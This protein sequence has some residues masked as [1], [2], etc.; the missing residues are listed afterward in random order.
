MLMRSGTRIGPADVLFNADLRGFI[1]IAFPQL[2]PDALQ[3]M[4]RGA[5]RA[6]LLFL[7]QIVLDGNARK[8][9]RDCLASPGMLFL[10]RFDL[11]SA[12]LMSLIRGGDRRQHLG[13]VEQHRLIG[14]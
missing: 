11:R 1:S 3:R 2:V 10:V 8:V 4:W 12:L 5:L 13:L 7:G 6:H 9:L 14:V